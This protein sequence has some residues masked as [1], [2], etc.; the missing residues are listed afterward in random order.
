MYLFFLSSQKLFVWGYFY[1]FFCIHKA[2][3]RS[4][5]GGWV[6]GCRNCNNALMDTFVYLQKLE[7]KFL[8]I[9]R[10]KIIILSMRETTLQG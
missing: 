7:E 5:C 2:N 4:V 9:P 8:N 10:A 1:V 3:F 6:G